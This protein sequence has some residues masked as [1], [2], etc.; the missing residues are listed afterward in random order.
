MKTR[1]AKAARL[2]RQFP[3]SNKKKGYGS[4]DILYQRVLGCG[5]DGRRVAL[6]VVRLGNVIKQLIDQ[7][8]IDELLH[9]VVPR[10]LQVLRL[11]HVV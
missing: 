6:K 11:V 8:P 4:V 10:P 1:C 3:F 9:H 2:A 5:L 7:V